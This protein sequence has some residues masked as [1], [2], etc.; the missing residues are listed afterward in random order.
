MKDENQRIPSSGLQRLSLDLSFILEEPINAGDVIKS[1]LSASKKMPMAT[2]TGVLLPQHE[3]YFP[4]VEPR[5]K[6]CNRSVDYKKRYN[7]NKMKTVKNSYSVH[8]YVIYRPDLYKYI[9]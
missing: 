7:N 1:I 8:D 6:F 3:P 9:T 4:A 5:K 2:F